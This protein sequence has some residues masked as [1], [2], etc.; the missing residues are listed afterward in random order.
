MPNLIDHKSRFRIAVWTSQGGPFYG[1]D[2][3]SNALS[4]SLIVDGARPVLPG[5]TRF[6]NVGGRTCMVRMN[7]CRSNLLVGS[8]CV[9]ANFPGAYSVSVQVLGDGHGVFLGFMSSNPKVL[10]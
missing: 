8:R 7:N 10:I 1:F 6:M 5:T 3:F 9:A 4:P 2:S